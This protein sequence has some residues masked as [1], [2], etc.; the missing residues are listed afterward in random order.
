MK[1]TMIVDAMQQNSGGMKSEED[2]QVLEDSL[3]SLSKVGVELRDG[4]L[5]DLEQ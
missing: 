3:A 2:K 4:R 1:S 5:V